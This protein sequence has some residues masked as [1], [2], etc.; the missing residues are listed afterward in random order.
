MFRRILRGD[1]ILVPPDCVVAAPELGLSPVGLPPDPASPGEG[2]FLSGRS[3]PIRATVS[4]PPPPDETASARSP[5]KPCG[6]TRDR[7]DEPK[8]RGARPSR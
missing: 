6:A 8:V 3:L 5:E 4:C 7:R 1:P 2:T